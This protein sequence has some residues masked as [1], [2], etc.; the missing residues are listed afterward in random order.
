MNKRGRTKGSALETKG[1]RT[2]GSALGT[3]GSALEV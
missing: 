1:Q 2:K 3:K